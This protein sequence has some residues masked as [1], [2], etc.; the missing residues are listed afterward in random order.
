MNLKIIHFVLALAAVCALA[1][2]APQ[3]A[4]A[5]SPY[6]PVTKYDPKRD[7]ARDIDDA[8]AEAKRSNRRILLIVGGEWCSWCH[9]LDKYFGV[10]PDVKALRDKNFVTVKINFS[11]ENPNEAVLSRYPP[12]EG[13]PHIFV[14]E[15]D[16]KFLHSQGTGVLESG[17]SYDLEKMNNF[18]KQWAPPVKPA[19]T[20]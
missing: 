8:V 9:I 18:L 3:S 13:Y 6:T 7:A 2:V 4:A 12:A 1:A 10:Q 14:L 11:D 16:G 17:N 5:Q 20:P 15:S 19:T